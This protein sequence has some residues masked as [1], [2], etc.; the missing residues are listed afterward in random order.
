MEPSSP[1]SK[2]DSRLLNARVAAEKLRTL[3]TENIRNNVFH[4]L[5]LGESGTGKTHLLRT[6]RKPVHIDSFDPGGTLHLRDLITK[7]DIIAD[8][9]YEQEDRTRP[10]A[11]AKWSSTF[12]QRYLSG[13]F[14]PFST[15]VLDSSTMWAEAIMNYVLGKADIA[16]E[17]PRFTKDYGPQKNHIYNGIR[18][19]LTL[20]CDVIITGHLTAE[21]EKRV[22]AGEVVEVKSKMEY[23]TTGVGKVI[24]PALFSE[25]WIA[26]AEPKG[27]EMT[28][29]ILTAKN[30]LYHARTRIGSGK[31]S[32]FETP[33]I[34]ALLKKAGWPTEDKPSLF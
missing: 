12:D 28:Y 27:T 23:M 10:S 11:Y 21:Y 13:Y 22:V 24:I 33:D 15:Y 6:V 3:Y 32:T 19:I 26:F 20:P 17:T 34:K 30:G 4:L 2:E 7:G 8:T 9:I 14:T 25:I 18:K 31:F 16:G 5:L 29:K 1:P